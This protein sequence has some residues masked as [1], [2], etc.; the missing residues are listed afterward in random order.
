MRRASTLALCSLLI[1]GCATR[2]SK[3][4]TSG[5]IAEKDKPTATPAAAG[6]VTPGPVQVLGRVIAVDQRT[7]SVIVELG[8]YVELPADFATRPLIA[9]R[10][11]LQPTARLQS[12]PYL[13][14]RT[15]G[16]RLV[17][18]Q[19]QVGDEVIF[20]PVAQ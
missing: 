16:T 1:A 17:A 12:S 4:S 5:G 13:R 20:P 18:G 19:P 6:P 2:G 11:D 7:L 15:L 14:G 3:S 8:P 9:R 10:D